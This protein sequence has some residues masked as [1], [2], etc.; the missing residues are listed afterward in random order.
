MARW[1]GHDMRK[2]LAML[3][4]A[5]LLGVLSRPGWAWRIRDAVRLKN[6]VPNELVGMGLVV[7]LPETGD[8][9]AFR[10]AMQPLMATLRRFD[11]PITLEK[12]L[13]NAKNVA[14]VLLSVSIPPQGVHA[15][16]SLDVKVS[17]I[18]AKGLKGGRLLVVPL[19]AP[20]AD[21]KMIL[22]S[23]SSANGDLVEGA[24]P[25]EATI[26]HGATMIQDVLPEEIRNN[27]FTMVIHPGMAARE[28]ATAIA[29]QINEDVSPQ[30]AGRAVAYAVDATS[31]QVT[32]PAAEQA[33]PTPFI[34]RLMTLPLPALP[35][36]ARVTIDTR[37]KVI[38]FSEEVEVAPTMISQGNL[39]ITIGSPGNAPGGRTPFLVLDPKGS[40]NAKLRDLQN[41]FSL[42]KVSPDDCMAIVKQLHKANALKAELIIE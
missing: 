24:V 42:L 33:N 11:N 19:Y 5:L 35:E 9:D 41:A 27:S 39:M 4:M 23:A 8:G 13:K 20:R 36:P 17:A 21:V 31:V 26:R 7:G 2:S 6:E 16:D 38:T 1:T 12:D 14:I 22:A 34:A 18:A 37:H 3:A 10:P 28:L 32:I 25:T 29:D 15:G 30:T 40:G